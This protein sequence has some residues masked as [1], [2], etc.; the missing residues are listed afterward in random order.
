MANTV[1]VTLQGKDNTGAAYTS[2][3]AQEK[4]YQALVDQSARTVEKASTNIQQARFKQVS[5]ASKVLDAER[6]IDAEA[7]KATGIQGELARVLDEGSR[8]ASVFGNAIGDAAGKLPG[9]VTPMVALVGAG[10]AL[11]PVIATLGTGLGGLGIAAAGII[12]PV[13]KAAQATGGLQ[14]NMSKLD[15]AQQQAARSLLGLQHSYSAFQSALK[16]VVLA[17]MN[18]AIGAA[19]PILRGVEPVAAATGNALAGLFHQ[20]GATFASGEWQSFFQFMAAQAG[21]D[22]QMLG[23]DI[24]DLT[25]TLPPL[26]RAL[27]PVAQGFMSGTS[28]VLNF[29]R[30]I[31]ALADAVQR[32]DASMAQQYP[33]LVKVEGGFQRVGLAVMTLGMSEMP[34]LWKWIGS[35]GQK[36]GET[37]GKMGVLAGSTQSEAQAAKDAAAALN[38]QREA[39]IK[40]LGPLNAYVDATITQRDDLKSLRTALQASGDKIGYNTQ[41]QRDAFGAA[42][43]YIKDLENTATQ[44]LASGQGVK[45]QA[46]AIHAALPV[47]SSV[48]GKTA[49]YRAELAALKA[50]YDQLKNEPNI[51][52]TFTFRTVGTGG[53]THAYPVKAQAHGGITGAASG[54]PRSNLTLVGE[55]GPEL[56]DLAPG[57]R[58]HSA[59]DSQRMLGAPAGV[60][61][62]QLVVSAAGQ[63]AFEA[64]ML[65]AIRE[66]VRVKGG[67]DVQ[68]A[69]GRA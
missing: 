8:G 50:I 15:P 19:G 68:K 58:V 36:S 35:I 10:V 65:K 28:A 33:T 9:M 62:V 48:T 29:T 54:G 55:Q 69:F 12:S 16:P 7:Q 44:A 63:S 46:S 30:G 39:F 25:Q 57:S 45:A 26:L 41:K 42:Q 32:Q 34:R 2:A 23:T 49:A 18:A 56:V 60:G 4:A 66:F 59:P 13:L 20:V 3:A 24:V 51:V 38:A 21:P 14:A 43:T 67:G 64:F 52:K 61:Q 31:G 47:L 40:G 5:A 11:T 6:F 22:M 53:M 17:D 27:N 37:S 1:E